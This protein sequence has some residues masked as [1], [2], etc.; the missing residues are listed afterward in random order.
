MELAK[1]KAIADE[2]VSKLSPFCS[3]IQVAGS[4]RRQKS[5]VRDIDL[6]LIPNNRG[7]FIYALQ[8][9]GRIKMGGSKV[10]RVGMGFTKGIDLDVY[11]ATTET[12][13]TL[14]LIRTG[15]TN[16]NIKLC[17][18]ALQQGKKLHA[19]GSGLFK[20]EAQ[21]CEGV[22]VRIAGDTETSIFAALGVP[23]K[24]PG[25]RN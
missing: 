5:T 4:I 24:E 10:I 16:H 15:S 23:Y 17:K 9:L 3:R 11:I 2:V 22:E 25:E 19:D 8:Q 13:A 12:W 20:I 18:L 21:G 7:Q 6:V 14:L 1:A